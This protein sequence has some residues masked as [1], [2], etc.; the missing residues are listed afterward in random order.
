MSTTITLA[1]IRDGYAVIANV[2][3]SRAY[4][5]N[6]DG[7]QQISVDHSLVQSLVEAG[8]LEPDQIYT[9]PQRNI[10]YRALG[11][12]SRT[13]VDTFPLELVPGDRLILCSDGLWEMTRDDGIE[14]TMLRELDP[15]VACDMLVEL[16]NMAGGTDNIS[17]IIVEITTNQWTVS[18]R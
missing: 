8:E 12:R 7:L 5:W 16:A 2:G 11:D 9:H 17:I 3:D 18:S 15:Q 13:E 1:V 10:I 6:A 4:R 14:E